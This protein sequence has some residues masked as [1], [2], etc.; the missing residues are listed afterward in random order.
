MQRRLG[1]EVFD[2]LRKAEKHPCEFT[3]PI[4]QMEIHTKVALTELTQYDG[5]PPTVIDVQELVNEAV[6]EIEQLEDGLDDLLEQRYP[7]VKN[8]IGS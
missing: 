8:D 1:S 6:A 3:A 2:A 4:G 5:K 7:T